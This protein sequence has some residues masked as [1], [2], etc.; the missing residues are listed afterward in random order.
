MNKNKKRTV[1]ISSIIATLFIAPLIVLAVV[2]YS[3]QRTNAFQPAEANIQVKE[4]NVCTDEINDTI[5]YKWTETDDS[6]Y[7]VDKPVQIYDERKKNDEYL[8][9]RFIPV[10]Y[11]NDGNV[12]GGIT[13]VSDYSTIAL[14]DA[15]DDVIT[16]ENDQQQATQLCFK[17]STGAI[18]LSM[19]LDLHWTNGWSYSMSDQCFYY[20]DRIK[21]GEFSSTLLKGA[22]ISKSV[23][24]STNDYTL[25]I[26]V[27]ADAIQTAGNAAETRMWATTAAPQQSP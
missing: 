10:W 11:D 17:D 5:D 7:T 12:C 6:Y 16:D 4:G 18:L 14:C 8:R 1:L 24:D 2:Y 15:S 27:L 13:G 3:N 19:Q 21:S 9:V 26:E 25:H 23:F 20:K 22:K